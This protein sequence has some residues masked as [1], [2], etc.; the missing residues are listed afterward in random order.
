[1]DDRLK[2]IIRHVVRGP[3]EEIEPMSHHHRY[4]P[5]GAE[6]WMNC[7][8]AL[9]LVDLLDL[10]GKADHST[11]EFAAYGTV[12][13]EIA[14]DCLNASQDAWE[15]AG[16]ERQEEGFTFEVDDE[17]TECIQVYLDAVREDLRK[18]GGSLHVERKEVLTEI[19]EECGGTMDAGFLGAD[20]VA[21]G[22]DFKSGF[23]FVDEEWNKQLL[24]YGLELVYK[25]LNKTQRKK[26]KEFELVIVQ[27]RAYG[28]APVR[29][30]RISIEELQKWMDEV[31]KPAVAATK[32]PEAPLVFGSWC[33]NHYCPA[34]AH[35]PVANA[36]ASEVIEAAQIAKPVDRVNEEELGEILALKKVVA[37]FF[38]SREQRAFEFLMKNRPVPGQK[39]VKADKRRVWKAA[40]DDS[41]PEDLAEEG[42]DRKMKTPAQFEK[43]GPKAKEFVAEWAHKPQGGLTMASADDKRPAE[44]APEDNPEEAFSHLIS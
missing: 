4:A 14:A 21:R 34:L 18:Y 3:I 33:T 22:Y 29:R 20:N 17:M 6:V 31:L 38:K 12:A 43:L 5:S 40:A 42:F 30:F 36:K 9:N 32:D 41:V 26:V 44:K 37:A 35:C 25:V 24:I 16:E 1:V 11:N 23:V 19:D 10:E 27:P 28:H 7:A 8:G 2:Q 15:F 39:L 13:H